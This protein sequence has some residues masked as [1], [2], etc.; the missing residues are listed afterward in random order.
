MTKLKDC[1]FCGKDVPID[2]ARVFEAEDIGGWL[3]GCCAQTWGET[4]EE[5]I[6][7]WNTRSMTNTEAVEALDSLAHRLRAGD[8]T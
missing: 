6:A 4:R 8:P 2:E 1:P 3:A 7:A 5:A